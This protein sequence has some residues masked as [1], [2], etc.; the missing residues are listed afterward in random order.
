MYR[1]NRII[2]CFLL[3]ILLIS[4]PGTASEPGVKII[5]HVVIIWLKPEFQTEEYIN[6][7]LAA[8]ER[9]REI[10]QVQ[11]LQTGR[12]LK[13][14]RKMVDDSFHI[15]NAMTFNSKQDMQDYLVHPIHVE[16]FEKYIKDKMEKAIV[17][18]F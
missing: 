2:F 16:F 12:A 17:F 4:G 9:L 5:T 14:D 3:S 10:P 8:N 18:D 11:S 15:G 13:S 1:K 6:E 7:V